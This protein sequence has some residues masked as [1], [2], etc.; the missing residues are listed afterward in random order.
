MRSVLNVHVAFWLLTLFPDILT[1]GAPA[2]VSFTST[3]TTGHVE[4]IVPCIIYIIANVFVSAQQQH[5]G[6][7]R[8]AW[9]GARL[10]VYML[11]LYTWF[12][13]VSYLTLLFV[14]QLRFSREAV[15]CLV[16]ST[17]P[18]TAADYCPCF[19]RTHISINCE[20]AWMMYCLNV[21]TKA[22]KHNLSVRQI[23]VLRS[24]ML[25]LCHHG[26]RVLILNLWYMLHH[27]SHLMMRAC[28]SENPELRKKSRIIY[29]KHTIWRNHF[30]LSC[31]RCRFLLKLQTFTCFN[32]LV[33]ATTV[34]RLERTC[35][36]TLQ[37]CEWLDL[38]AAQTMFPASQYIVYN[39]RHRKINWSHLHDSLRQRSWWQSQ[40]ACW[41]RW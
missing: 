33:Q 1:S 17:A 16:L 10:G 31:I 21:I 22:E 28:E 18:R 20:Q 37:C 6:I 3:K 36:A 35:L 39:I 38:L 4:Q 19:A 29:I 13:F 11:I 25:C 2:C 32:V 40:A 23:S 12:D 24:S 7:K 41:N 9:V 5:M 15:M 26:M 34:I 30:L 14:L 27:H 8:I